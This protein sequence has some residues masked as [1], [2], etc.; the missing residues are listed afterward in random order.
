[1]TRSLFCSAATAVLAMCIPSFA[2]SSPPDILFI[3]IDDTGIDQWASFG[4][5]N[6]PL[7]RAPD[8]PV[9]DAITNGG[10]AFTN[11]WAM[12]ECSPSRT[13]FF[14]GRLPM[15]TG[16]DAAITT[17]HLPASMA[18]TA[19]V[20]TPKV[21]QKAGYRCGFAGKW[22]SGEVPWNEAQ[23]IGM[24]WDWYE[25]NWLGFVPGI[26]S[27]AG[28][29]LVSEDPPAETY[30]NGWIPCGAPLGDPD[31]ADNRGP[32]CLSENECVE[33]VWGM[34]CLQMGGVPLMALEVGD[35][36]QM[37]PVFEASC[38]LSDT[39]C[40]E[41]LF[42]ESKDG[43]TTARNGYW[44]WGRQWA[45]A[46]TGKKGLV[47]FHH[48]GMLANTTDT[49]IDWLNRVDPVKNPSDEPW[50][51]ALQYNT[52]HDPIMLNS[53][54][55]VAR[56]EA[57]G[58]DTAALD[59]GGFLGIKTVFPYMIEEADGEIGKLLE[60]RGLGSYNKD[61]SFALGDLDAAN[62][63]IVWIGDNG[64]FYSS[65]RAPFNPLLSKATVYQT[66]VWVPLVVAGAGVAVGEV[67]HPVNAVDLFGL[68]ADLAGVDTSNVVP[69]SHQL[70]SVSLSEYLTDPSAPSTR[71]FNLSQNG[72]GIFN[73]FDPPQACVI[74]LGPTSV[75][76]DIHFTG[77]GICESNGGVWYGVDSDDPDYP[78]TCCDYMTEY[79]PK[80]LPQAQRQYAI[81]MADDSSAVFRMWKLI[82]TQPASCV[83]ALPDYSCLD[84]IE[85][86]RLPHDVPPVF[87]ALDNPDGAHMIVLPDDPADL[88]STLTAEE[89][90]AFMSLAC[91]LKS[92]WASADSCLADGNIDGHVDMTDLLGVLLD[93]GGTGESLSFFDVTGS[94]GDP[95]GQ[96]NMDDL[97]LVITTWSGDSACTLDDPYPG[98]DCLFDYAIDC[99]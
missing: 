73:P 97:M 54:S 80:T 69:A 44:V 60:V 19:E 42:T 15:R 25:G 27:T 62:T 61:G 21:L 40:G 31:D 55:L 78:V 11:C 10:V 50:F 88:E 57:D 48:G 89:Y 96:V 66:G 65:T 12:P 71:E 83:E 51:L 7:Q 70:D 95:D 8:T 87:A 17:A 81:S 24:G 37:R 82:A 14:T 4:W 26:D 28:Q 46:D 41:I 35:D 13:A 34:D 16:V 68:F 39:G 3:V 53:P 76:D 29:Q 30:P 79:D 52:A 47:D 36:G 23:P 98:A 86:Y 90:E 20:M 32:C 77:A 5:N 2:G 64:T 59:C 74:D 75:C 93:W 84:N 72:S 33:D 85:F 56:M 99:P 58:I 63:V 6:D 67:D 38:D 91:E 94:D 43:D 1:M 92:Q 18:N 49:A 22:H 45:D 9:L